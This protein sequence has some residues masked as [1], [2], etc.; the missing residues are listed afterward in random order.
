MRIETPCGLASRQRDEPLFPAAGKR[1]GHDRQRDIRIIAC[2]RMKSTV[3]AGRLVQQFA[4]FCIVGLDEKICTEG[5][6]QDLSR[7]AQLRK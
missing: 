2:A 3:L 1:F 4:E 6:F 7:I 5:C